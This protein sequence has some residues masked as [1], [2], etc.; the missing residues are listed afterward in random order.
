MD[1][2]QAAISNNHKVTIR[3]TPDDRS[4][5]SPLSLLGQP[6]CSGRGGTAPFPNFDG[7]GPSTPETLSFDPTSTKSDSGNQRRGGHFG[8][9][10]TASAP[11]PGAHSAISH[12]SQ[13]HRGRAALAVAASPELF[14][15]AA[16]NQ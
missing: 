1:K 8:D 13:A 12:L 10:G 7:R 5:P 4:T 3:F 2:R 6:W 16:G 9:G 15:S 14:V 11:P